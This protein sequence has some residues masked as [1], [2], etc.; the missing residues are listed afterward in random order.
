MR[1]LRGGYFNVVHHQICPQH[2]ESDDDANQFGTP[3]WHERR[4]NWH[5][6]RSHSNLAQEKTI[7]T[8]E[9]QFGTKKD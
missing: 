5:E 3:I 2:L 7:G 4:L 6:R 1:A 8:E 9:D